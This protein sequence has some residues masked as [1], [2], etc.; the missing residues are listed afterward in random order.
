MHLCDCFTQLMACV[1]YTLPEVE[2]HGGPY[3]DFRAAVMAH[4]DRCGDHPARE[5]V[6]EE[7]FALAR[8]AVF[9]WVDDRVMQS[10]WE[11]K[12]Q[13]QKESLQRIHYKT[14]QGGA[15]FFTRLKETDASKGELL[16]VFYLCLLAGFRG[17]YGMDEES[18]I[19][20]Q[21]KD[22]TLRKMG[23][24]EERLTGDGHVK[25]FPACYGGAPPSVAAKGRRF[26]MSPLRLAGL[27][28]PVVLCALLF[29]VYRFVLNSEIMTN[30]VP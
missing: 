25:L 5:G 7:E 1:A 15:E 23:I 20:D 13:W 29:G 21:I 2:K 24:H 28:V 11:G 12:T 3:D 22:G 27:A 8:F 30:L 18:V 14:A 9:C 6:G 19:L 4:V 26:A 17:R 10:A 16:E